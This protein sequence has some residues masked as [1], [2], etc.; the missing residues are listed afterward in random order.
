MANS[1]G[2]GFSENLVKPKF[3]S[4]KFRNDFD[5]DKHDFFIGLGLEDLGIYEKR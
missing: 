2:I 5:E 3:V 4:C 1:L